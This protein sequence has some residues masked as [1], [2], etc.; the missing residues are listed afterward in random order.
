MT[1]LSFQSQCYTVQVWQQMDDSSCFVLCVADGESGAYLFLSGGKLKRHHTGP[2]GKE[3]LEAIN[4]YFLYECLE[5]VEKMKFSHYVRVVGWLRALV[6]LQSAMENGLYLEQP[7]LSRS[8][9]DTTGG[10]SVL[11]HINRDS[12]RFTQPELYHSYFGGRIL[13]E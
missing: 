11:E 3:I 6:K 13:N 9:V 7:L 5:Q 4:L 8:Y 10:A 1:I 12:L 2:F